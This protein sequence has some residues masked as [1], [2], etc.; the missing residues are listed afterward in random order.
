MVDG[1][2]ASG[3][4]SG[5][6]RGE[7]A[8]EPSP[9][10]AAGGT[11]GLVGESGCG[12]STLGRA[13]LRLHEP[14]SGQIWLDG[15]DITSLT[16]PE[17]VAWRRRM[18]IIFQ[19]PYA[20]LSPRRTVRQTIR[21]ALDT[22]SIG[23]DAGRDAEVQRLLE[24]VGLRRQV[25]E[26]G[27]KPAEADPARLDADASRAAER[28]FIEVAACGD[29]MGAFCRYHFTD[30]ASRQLVVVTRGMEANAPVEFVG[31]TPRDY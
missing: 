19:D 8:S 4:V 11:F 9:R 27:W 29:A 2:A 1:A 3:S 5:D 21:E 13:V 26:A 25:L 28:G 30:A 18:Q 10:V 31:L 23:D 20:S 24:V 6:Y 16:A 14:T 17:L 22:H 15:T 12:K 7:H